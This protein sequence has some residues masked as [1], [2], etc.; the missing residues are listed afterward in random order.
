VTIFAG[1]VALLLL[2]FAWYSVRR[3]LKWGMAVFMVGLFGGAGYFVY[4][5]FKIWQERTGTYKEVYKSLT[6]FT[7][8]ALGLL[9]ATFIMSVRCLM[10]FDMGLKGAMARTEEAQKLAKEGG[11][12][13]DTMNI[14][15][16]YHNHGGSSYFT[17]KHLRG[18]SKGMLPLQSASSL[19]LDRTAH[20][21]RLSLD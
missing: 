16:P 2:I 7:V 21:P 17:S 20:N 8:L 6:V 5:T 19:H 12:A 13:S 3:E 15:S 1:P 11:T 18:T 9:V 14:S 10:N 4:K